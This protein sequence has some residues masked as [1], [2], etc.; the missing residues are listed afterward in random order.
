MSHVAHES[1]QGVSGGDTRLT[2][3]SRGDSGMGGT[4]R[5]PG[6]LSRLE[7]RRAAQGE[8]GGVDVPELA[9]FVGAKRTQLAV[10][11]KS[12]AIGALRG[13]LQEVTRV[14]SMRPQTFG[15]TQVL[16]RLRAL[17]RPAVPWGESGR[18]KGEPRL[19]RGPV[20]G[21]PG[22]HRVGP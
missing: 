7:W 14:A 12:A 15:R 8:T 16:A 21:I 13:A 3:V 20:L 4:A 10:L 2:S 1:G 19:T 11:S 22:T 18:E 17:S 9:A 5:K 6:R